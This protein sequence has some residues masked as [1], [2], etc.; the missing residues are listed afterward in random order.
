MIGWDAR[1]IQGS[2]ESWESFPRWLGKFDL[3]RSIRT[4][5][6]NNQTIRSI[7]LSTFGKVRNGSSFKRVWIWCPPLKFLWQKPWISLGFPWLKF[8][9]SRWICWRFVVSPSEKLQ[10]RS[11]AGKV[12]SQINFKWQLCL[13]DTI[14]KRTC[15]SCCPGGF[16]VLEGYRC[17]APALFSDFFRDLFKICRC[18]RWKTKIAARMHLLHMFCRWWVFETNFGP[19][20]ILQ[21][22]IS[23]ELLGVQFFSHPF[24][25]LLM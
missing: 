24:D 4:N 14:A 3:R 19:G 13:N 9:S 15:S 20:C 25:Q 2:W 6:E 17:S 12:R 1:F 5:C 22:L 23:M 18:V 7:S 21:F 11:E 10:T 8:G 16:T